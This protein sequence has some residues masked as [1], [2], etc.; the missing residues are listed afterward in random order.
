MYVSSSTQLSEEEQAAANEPEGDEEDPDGTVST[1]E[2]PDGTGT[3]G[4]IASD[5][6]RASAVSSVGTPDP[7][8]DL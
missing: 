6:Q 5:T 1:E 8:D 4:A 3:G 2:D 7:D